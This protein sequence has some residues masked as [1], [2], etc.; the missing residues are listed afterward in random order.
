MFGKWAARKGS[1]GSTARWTADAFWGGL[2]QQIIDIENVKTN[3]GL[4]IELDKLVEFALGVRFGG[5]V[6]HPE[7]GQ[8]LSFYKSLNPGLASFTISI[9]AVEAEYFK[10]T[11]ANQKMFKE[12]IIEELEK[13]NVGLKMI[14]GHL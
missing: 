5:D 13:K 4:E 9:L 11:E 6:S 8:I 10:N 2:S 1:I 7:L 12:V 14:H 3:E